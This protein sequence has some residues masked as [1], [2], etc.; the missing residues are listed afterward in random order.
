MLAHLDVETVFM[1]V[2]TPGL[3]LRKSPTGHGTRMGYPGAFAMSASP[4]F[5]GSDVSKAHL[6][7]DLRPGGAFRVANGA[8]GLAA[9]VARLAPLAPARWSSMPPTAAMLR[10]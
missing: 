2:V 1:T 6:D 10:P 4:T 8:N 7:V 9:L 5:V 3:P